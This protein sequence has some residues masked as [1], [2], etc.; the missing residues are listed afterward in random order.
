MFEGPGRFVVRQVAEAGCPSGGALVRVH[1]CAVCGTDVRIV[2]HGHHK[3]R[4]P[5]ILGHEVVGTVVAGDCA[6]AVGARVTIAPAVGCGACRW[7]RAGQ[8][9]RCPGLE[10]IGY[11]YP[12]AFAPLLPVPAEAVRQGSV[13]AVPDGL[14]D[15]AACLAE[16]LACCLN[17]Q[18]LVGLGPGDRVVIVG[19]GPIGWLHARLATARGAA[20]VL[21]V[22]RRPDRREAGRRAGLG[23]VIE[24]DDPREAI[25][26]ATDGAGCDVAMVA[27]PSAEA[28]V[29]ALGWLA[30]GGRLSWFGGL[31]PETPPLAVPSNQVHYEE[32]LIVGAHGSTPAQNRQALELLRSGVVRV[33]DLITGRYGLD[34]APAAVAAMAEGRTLKSVVCPAD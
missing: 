27:A 22:E 15:L 1:C 10:T 17:G 5:Q 19:L 14:E 3:V 20:Q 4:P 28:Q 34:Q 7:C 16:P 11:Y 2:R 31:P 24:A 29:Q 9:N 25:W 26:S 13:C 32:L 33:D 12:G 30:R 8:P 6:V 23:Q 21:L 18:E